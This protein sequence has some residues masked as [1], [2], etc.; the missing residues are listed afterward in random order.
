MAK[1][2][3]AEPFQVNVLSEDESFNGIRVRK[4]IATLKKIGYNLQ[5]VKDTYQ[6]M[7]AMTVEELKIII[8]DDNATILEKTIAQ[9]LGKGMA[10]GR[11]W[12]IETMLTRLYGSPEINN[13]ID[14]QTS[15]N[16]IT[17]D[18]TKLLIDKL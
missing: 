5:E 4:H 17:D 15:I 1:K 10:A 13:N 12:S 18:K 7:L 11:I 16:V 8:T 2:K 3:L 9:A 14:L 6:N